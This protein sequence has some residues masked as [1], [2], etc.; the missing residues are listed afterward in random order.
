MSREEAY[1]IVQRNALRA[2]DEGLPFR[3]LLEVDARGVG[4]AST[5]PSSTAVFDLDG[6]LRHVDDDLRPDHRAAGADPCLRRWQALH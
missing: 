2:W 1:E 6:F 4:G 3:G 5:R